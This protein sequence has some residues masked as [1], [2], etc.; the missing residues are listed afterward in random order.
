M[1]KKNDSLCFDITSLNEEQKK[2]FAKSLKK[3]MS[4]F[5]ESLENKSDEEEES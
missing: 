4:D 5:N 2:T 3:T 1:T